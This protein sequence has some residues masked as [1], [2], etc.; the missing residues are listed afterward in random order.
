MKVVSAMAG[1]EEGSRTLG[2]PGAG[3]RLGAAWCYYNLVP[4]GTS[5]SAGGRRPAVVVLE[6]SVLRY[7]RVAG[8]LAGVRQSDGLAQCWWF[9][10]QVGLPAKMCLR[11]V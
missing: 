2:S 11:M 4:S 7:G 1:E 8:R 9:D 3:S 6:Q 10:R 5:L